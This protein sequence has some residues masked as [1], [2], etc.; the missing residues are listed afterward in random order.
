MILN[1]RQIQQAQPLEPLLAK[2]KQDIFGNKQLSYGLSSFGYDISLADTQLL[3][4]K[5][6][7]GCIDPKGFDQQSLEPAQLYSDAYSDWFVLPPYSAALGVSVEKFNMP[8]DMVGLVIGKSSYARCNIIVNCT[9]LEPGWRGYLTLELV[10]S[11]P[12]SVIVYANE[13]IAQVLFFRGDEPSTTY[14][15]GK[16]QDQPDKPVTT[17]M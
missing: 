7:A 5:P 10:N 17:K 3:V 13:G 12:N 8:T 11:S 9:L 16:Y 6:V 14:E 4:S 15:G 2:V 1:D